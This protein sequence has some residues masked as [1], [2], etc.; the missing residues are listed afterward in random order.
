M[1]FVCSQRGCEFESENAPENCPVCNNPFIKPFTVEPI[2]P[3][4][5]VEPV[6]DSGTD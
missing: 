4:E 2:E 6:Y 3:V 1:K 5:P